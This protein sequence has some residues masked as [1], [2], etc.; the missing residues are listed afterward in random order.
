MR[1]SVS[2]VLSSTV[3]ATS[4]VTVTVLS[5]PPVTP[6]A[7]YPPKRPTSSAAIRAAAKTG[8]EVPPVGIKNWQ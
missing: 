5:P 8:L 3:L 6:A 4:L 2:V 7:R 1:C